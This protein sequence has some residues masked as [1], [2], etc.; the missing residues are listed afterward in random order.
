MHRR[1]NGGCE[2]SV[3]EAVRM[4]EG[5]GRRLRMHLVLRGGGGIAECGH[6]HK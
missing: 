2:E 1:S 3:E 6:V 5:G 4:A